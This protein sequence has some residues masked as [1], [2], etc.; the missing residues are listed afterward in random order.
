[1]RSASRRTRTP[2]ARATP[3]LTHRQTA[4]RFIRRPLVDGGRSAG[5]SWTGISSSESNP[6][7]DGFVLSIPPNVALSGMTV[8]GAT[9]Q[10]WLANRLVPSL[11]RGVTLRGSV[12]HPFAVARDQV[13]VLQRLR[14]LLHLVLGDPR[15]LRD[16]A[17]LPHRRVE[18]GEDL[19]DRLADRAAAL[20][21]DIGAE[22]LHHAESLAE[23]VRLR[24][25]RLN[26]LLD[27]LQ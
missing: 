19:P 24:N 12:P 6:S 10:F 3:R 16:G 2:S 20:D 8:G 15:K 18:G 4:A 5:R 25:V 22:L 7:A 14:A 26:E 17:E 27:L 13:V 1:M 21:D 11:D 23:R 9:V